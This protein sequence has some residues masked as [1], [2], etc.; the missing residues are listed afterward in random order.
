MTNIE[1]TTGKYIR[2]T[3]QGV[4]YRVYFEESGQG[5]PLVCQHTAGSDCR[6]WRHLLNDAEVTS[7]YRVIAFDLPYHGKSL[8]PETL[9]WWKEE[10]RLHKSFLFDFHTEFG[11]ALGLERPVYI[12]CSMGGHL[13]PDLALERPDIYRAVIGVQGTAHSGH[14]TEIWW[15]HP[16]VS[17]D[18]R[19]HAMM[20]MQSPTS[21][22]KYRRETAWE[23]SQSAPFVF[24]GDLYYYF[25]EHDV[26]KTAEN[27]D[28]SRCAVYLMAGE[29]DPDA[30][31]DEGRRLAG[32]IKG[33]KFVAMEG[34]GH[35]GMCENY[36]VFKT[37]LMPFLREIAN[38][39]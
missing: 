22:E 18:F 4:E 25:A 7:M 5:I 37:Y 2:L 3:V 10:Y 27:I 31:P 26:T 38:T 15:Y 6:Q 14:S 9:E 13:A 35:F 20:A 33:S 36:P 23:Y 32:M 24:K 30:N 19:F 29:Y 11:K 34:L 1:P 12:G 39:D 17:N 8:P 21:P 28:T 16:K